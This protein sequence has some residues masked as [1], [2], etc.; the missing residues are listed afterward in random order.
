MV[1]YTCNI[2]NKTFK[3]KSHYNSHINRKIP[4]N[5]TNLTD[6]HNSLTPPLRSLTEPHKKTL[7]NN[8]NSCKYCNI[9]FSRRD[10]LNRHIDRYCK[11]KNEHVIKLEREVK[12]LKDK[13]ES[14][15]ENNIIINN[16]Y[17]KIDISNNIQYNI[18]NN[19]NIELLTFGQEEYE[20]LTQDEK[21]DIM[22]GA[23][24]AITK[25]IKHTHF[26][27]NK[28][29]NMNVYINN[30]RS[31]L[32]DVYES[33][34]W[35]KCRTDNITDM[36]ISHSQRYIE[37]IFLENKNN[38]YNKFLTESTKDLIE[39]ID[40]DKRKV[41]KDQKQRI[42]ITLYNEKDKVIENKKKLC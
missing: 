22:E 8:D 33:G 18:Q 11:Q 28:P 13:L 29:Q 26:N 12:E 6:P 19:N 9:I 7:D 16:T 20:L 35:K 23:L 38:D 15:K 41:I 21:K 30:V 31:N 2:C 17:N 25:C 14:N 39:D 42:I 34:R 27:E 5:N 37:K 24:N 10:N 36:L 3:R 1:L 32:T 40:N 4:C